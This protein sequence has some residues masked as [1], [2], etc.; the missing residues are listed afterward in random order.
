M[1]H[2]S[3]IMNVDYFDE[4]CIREKPFDAADVDALIQRCAESGV[5]TI[6]WRAIGLGV[7]GYSSRLLQ[8]PDSLADCDMSSFLSRAHDDQKDSKA[9]SKNFALQT[10][11]R[12]SLIA[13]GKRIAA[14]LQQMDPIAIA[15]DACRRHGLA[16]YI[17]LDFFD[18]QLNRSLAEHP[19]WRVLGKDGITTFPGLRSYAVAE[20]V[21]DQLRV[22]EE[23]LQYHPNGLYLCTSCHNRH[24]HFPE[25]DDFFGFE[26]PVVTAC[27][28]KGIDIRSESFD[29]E[30]WHEVKG[31][32]ITDFFRRVKQLARSLGIKLAIGTQLGTHTILT[33]PVFSTHIPYRFTTQWK[34]WIDESIADILILG[35]Y[36]WP[37]DHVP[38]W[39]AKG[40]NWPKS[41][42]PAD[43]EW[44]PYTEYAAGRAEFY[45]FSSWLS[46][47]AAH[48]VG[49][50]TGSLAEAMQMRARTLG[51]T[52]V[53]GICLH[54]AM[55]FER[56]ETGF[57]TVAEMRRYLDG[58]EIDKSTF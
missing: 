43:V 11:K 21:A 24:L 18:E 5:D 41:T 8:P 28:Q 10:Q 51:A 31:D 16:F 23:L 6:F 14:S 20:A 56:E 2:K 26:E 13:W 33:S 17:W 45:W 22:I 54:E 7:A 53:N 25:P 36:E 50:S 29:H 15:R 30:C 27:K 32:F 38:I 49:A 39:E 9:N 46:A 55:T 40:M 58:R 47:Y 35:D 44:K 48:H 19:E 37:W 3:I 4:V 34:K 57:Q 12:E 42:F 52:P 1:P